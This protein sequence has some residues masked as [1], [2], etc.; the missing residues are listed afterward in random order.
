M[1][2]DE[3]WTQAMPGAVRLHARRLSRRGDAVALLIPPATLVRVYMGMPDCLA[4]ME[5]GEAEIGPYVQSL[6]DRG[7]TLIWGQ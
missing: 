5:H 1:T 3:V 4:N 7:Y 2:A 6:T